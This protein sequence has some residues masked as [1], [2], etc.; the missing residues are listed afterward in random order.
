MVY[1][2]TKQPIVG[3]FVDTFA[4]SFLA[5]ISGSKAHGSSLDGQA[6][7]DRSLGSTDSLFPRG[8]EANGGGGLG[9]YV[10]EAFDGGA[11]LG[12]EEL[13]GEVEGA[14]AVGEVGC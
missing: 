10:E 2:S 9:G 6:L 8:E 13:G 3:A 5:S 7:P 14:Q 12:V 1:E 11:A 4:T